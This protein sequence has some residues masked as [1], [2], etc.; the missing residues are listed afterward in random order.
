MII[1]IMRM[2]IAVLVSA[3]LGLCVADSLTTLAVLGSGRGYEANA[4]ITL[5]ASN[6]AFHAAK[7]LL[8]ALIL[9]GIHR[10]CKNDEKMEISSYLTLVIFYSL[11]VANNVSVYIAGRGLNFN[12][13]K[14]I[15]LFFGTFLAVYALTAHTHPTKT[16]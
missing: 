12:L 14:M 7:F 10:V 9:Y 2:K 15:V 11:V 4:A 13:P 16:E 3:V 1:V 6:P 8:T 5:F